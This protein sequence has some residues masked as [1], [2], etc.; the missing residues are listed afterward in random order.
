MFA[1]DKIYTNSIWQVKEGQEQNFKSLWKEFAETA[2][3]EKGAIEGVL[4][5]EYDNPRSFVSFGIWEN[6]ESAKQLQNSPEMKS[7]L[8]KFDEICDS[9]QLKILKPVVNVKK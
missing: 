6:I 2:V 9:R 1:E 4:M 8:P 7:Y 5:Q 3:K